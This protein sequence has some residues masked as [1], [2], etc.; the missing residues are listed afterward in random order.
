MAVY[1]AAGRDR[2][3]PDP[4]L[5][6][7]S[8]SFERDANMF[9]SQRLAPPVRVNLQSG[10][11]ELFGKRSFKNPAFGSARAPGTRANE[12]E[13]GREAF[14]DTYFA[15]E[16]ALEIGI[17][18]EEYE[19]NPDKDVRAEATEEVTGQ[20]MTQKELTVVNLVTDASNYKASHV[21]TLGAGEHFDEYSTSEPIT[22]FRDLIRQF[23][24]STGI[25]PNLG[26]FPWKVMSFLEDHPDIIA[27]Y[28]ARGGNIS[29][30]NIAEALHLPE[31]IVP[32]GWYDENTNPAL[33]ASLKEF[34]PDDILLAYVPN[35]PSR[36]T[37][38]LMY[39]FVWP[40]EGGRQGPDN[41][42]T[43]VRYDDDNIRDLVRVRTRRD[44]K[45]VGKDPEETG[46]PIIAGALIK[47]VLTG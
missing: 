42:S 16:D 2:I 41:F 22:V 47:D 4:L 31:I 40:I 45:L 11:Y 28:E 3:E 36:R 46:T 1:D 20:L 34:W 30:E 18:I 44:I 25:T 7:V 32:G 6:D 9:V 24:D 5:S 10:R 8:I 39:D 35:R 27:R 12:V 14:E 15:T 17:P 43:D 21:V 33:A 37:P 26:V 29:P 19:N 13:S 23:F 38:A